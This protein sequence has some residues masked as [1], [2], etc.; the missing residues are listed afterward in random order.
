[1]P[2]SRSALCIHRHDGRTP[3]ARRCTFDVLENHTRSL[4]GI[5]PDHLCRPQ[6]MR[7][8]LMLSRWKRLTADE[9]EVE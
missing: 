5:D 1:M 9:L 4:F 8:G 6:G 2:Q 7:C 3:V